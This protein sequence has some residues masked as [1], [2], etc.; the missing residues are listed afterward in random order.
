VRNNVCFQ[1]SHPHP[2][3][4][5]MHAV[6]SLSEGMPA[7]MRPNPARAFAQMILCESQDRHLA[8]RLLRFNGLDE[9]KRARP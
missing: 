7:A 5:Q 1:G 4:H 2:L 6:V 9:S 3:T 8:I